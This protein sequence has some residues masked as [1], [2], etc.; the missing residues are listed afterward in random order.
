M[1]PIATLDIISWVLVGAGLLWFI[2]YKLMFWN[3]RSELRPK[4]FPDVGRGV[5]TLRKAGVQQ[6][7]DA[8]RAKASEGSMDSLKIAVI[9]ADTLIDS[10]LK[11][12][13]LEGDHM[14]DRLDQL[15]SDDIRSIDRVWRAHRYRNEL[16][17][18]RGAVHAER[19]A[20]ALEGFEAFLK[21]VGI[22]DH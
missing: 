13:G 15:S 16:V 17:H 10:L 18:E 9:E 7:W 11:D 1:I 22:I 19:A 20:Q 12:G 21:E 2:M 5:V 8:I 14:A 3:A 6:K 4:F